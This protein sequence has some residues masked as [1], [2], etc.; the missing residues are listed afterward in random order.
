MLAVILMMCVVGMQAHVPMRA[1][2]GD[3]GTGRN[4]NSGP[5]RIAQ[6]WRGQQYL[7]HHRRKHK[8]QHGQQRY[9]C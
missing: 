7:G 8:H 1:M 4:M 9:P 2:A 5:G 6:D 3:I